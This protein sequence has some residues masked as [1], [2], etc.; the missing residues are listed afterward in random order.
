MKLMDIVLLSLAAGFVIIG[1]YEVMTLG[2]GHA[3]WAI[4]LAFG[5]FF[6]YTYR[7]KK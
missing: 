5:F 4:M 7:K 1:I 6:I 3:Y 2:L